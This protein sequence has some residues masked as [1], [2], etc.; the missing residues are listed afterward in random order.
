MKYFLIVLVAVIIIAFF[1]IKNALDKFTF[2]DV[3][4]VGGDFRSI[5]SGQPF[6]AINLSETI[7]NKNNFNV[8]V[9]GL[10][11]E[12]YHQGTLIASSTAP[13]ADFVI[14]ANGTYTLN[15][16]MTV[17]TS[18]ALSIATK[19]FSGQPL[20]F[21]YKI[22]AKLFGFYPLSYNGNFTY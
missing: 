16:S 11:V 12:V 17:D 15:Q 1:Y 22:K 13:Q 5:I 14:P 2:G 19:I 3:K 9:S 21:D 10:N 20:V 18:K 4:F 8:P 6:T 7:E